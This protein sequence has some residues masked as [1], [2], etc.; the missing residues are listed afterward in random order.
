[1]SGSRWKKM[2][3]NF[4]D[5]VPI[6]R[7]T[8]RVALS[9]GL[10]SLALQSAPDAAAQP[11]VPIVPTFDPE[12]NVRKFKGKYVLRRTS[13]S[14]FMHLMGHRSHSSHAS[15]ASHSSHSSS[16]HYSGS[17]FS[18]SPSPSPSPAPPTI[19]EPI[20]PQVEPEPQPASVPV[21]RRGAPKPR[22]KPA[23]LLREDFSTPVDGRWT[24]G[25]LATP[26]STFDE[27][28]TV[29]EREGSLSVTP[30]SRK[31]GSHFSGYISNQSFDLGTATISAQ[32]RHASGVTIFAA[33]IDDRNW[34]GFRIDGGELAIESHSAGK[35]S[36]RK[37]PYDATQHRFLR[38]RT[39]SVAAVVV[40]E[41]SADGINWNPEYVETSSMKLSALRIALS[42]GTTHAIATTGAAQFDN[43]T[44]EV[45]R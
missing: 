8:G 41:T 29:S 36:G 17:H 34:V 7:I 44:V 5:V 26:S 15:H 13:T 10:L 30:A 1:M 24:V 16:S 43:V 14:Y 35:V 25:V 9:A 12:A 32:V 33:A 37:V 45:R 21:P 3:A 40:W 4:L 28:I 23:P 39:S 20:V 38:V 2:V 42:A 22:P 27:A 18:S 19:I 11:R 6:R 31:S